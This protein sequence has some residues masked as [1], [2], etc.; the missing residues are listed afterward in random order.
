[1]F[2]QINSAQKEVLNNLHRFVISFIHPIRCTK[3]TANKVIDA[4]QNIL[5]DTLENQHASHATYKEM[6][7][8]G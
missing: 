5:S 6:W 3:Y 1:M 2:V 7:K 8:A 4:F